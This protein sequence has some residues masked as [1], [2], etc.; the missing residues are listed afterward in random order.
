MWYVGGVCVVGVCGVC[1]GGGWYVCVMCVMCG[2]C[3]GSVCVC[4][5]VC[6]CGVSTG[7][8]MATGRA[9]K[10]RS[11]G[12]WE[13]GGLGVTLQSCLRPRGAHWS[14]GSEGHWL[15]MGASKG[16]QGAAP[17]CRKPARWAQVLLG[18]TA[19]GGTDSTLREKPSCLVA[20]EQGRAGGRP[21][22]REGCGWGRLALGSM[23]CRDCPTVE[24]R[25]GL[26]AGGLKQN[27]AS[28]P[29]AKLHLR[30]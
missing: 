11:R 27:L 3:V 20:E 15:P 19:L 8:A 26:R 2:V 30:D 12:T 7:S 18:Q 25:A 1:V 9:A 21:E 23:G 10:G 14:L 5:C 13:P 22:P 28:I 4:V 17:W 6:V 29:N 24:G 16:T